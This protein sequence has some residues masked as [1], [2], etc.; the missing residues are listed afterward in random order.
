MTQ[1]S[2]VGLYSDGV[3]TGEPVHEI[4][5]EKP[6]ST[7]LVNVCNFCVQIPMN[8]AGSIL[9]EINFENTPKGI[10]TIRF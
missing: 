8:T 9:R 10:L 7:Q 1:L 6:Q 4:V 5:P 2:S 3:Q